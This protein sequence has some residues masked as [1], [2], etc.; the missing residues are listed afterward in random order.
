MVDPFEEEQE[1]PI[2][3]KPR[4]SW[5]EIR[6][7]Y[8]KSPW[9]KNFYF[10]HWKDIVIFLLAVILIFSQWEN[11]KEYGAVMKDPCKFCPLYK[12]IQGGDLLWNVDNGTA[13]LT[14]LSNVSQEAN[15]ESK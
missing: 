9:Y 1:E 10:V 6:A 11:N 7:A 2:P 14:A 13:T 4:K 12:P 8:W 3:E 15:Q 5:A